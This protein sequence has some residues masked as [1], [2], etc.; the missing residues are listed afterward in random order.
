MNTPRDQ[1]EI[2]HDISRIKAILD[3]DIFAQENMSHP[4]IPSA[5]TELIICL[6]DLLQK[7]DDLAKSRVSFTDDIEITA[8]LK[9]ITDL[10]SKVRNAVCHIPS[11][12]HQIENTDL[13]FTFNVIYGEGTLAQFGAHSFRSE[14][15][16]EVC[17]FFG[18][19]RIYLKRHIIRAFQEA[20]H[21]LVQL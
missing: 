7:S 1:F 9:D 12:A 6:N 19:N 5:F 8:K 10:V 15:T 20:K 21:K 4:L 16:D 3:T 11:G 2:E 14:Y 13:I 17:F 18:T